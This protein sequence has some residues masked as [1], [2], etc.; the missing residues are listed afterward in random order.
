MNSQIALKLLGLRKA[1]LLLAKAKDHQGDTES[2][3]SPLSNALR[4]PASSPNQTNSSGQIREVLKEGIYPVVL[5]DQC[6]AAGIHADLLPLQL[7]VDG[8]SGAKTE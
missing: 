2:F 8:T 6:R 1:C 5:Q 4:T 3:S 7:L